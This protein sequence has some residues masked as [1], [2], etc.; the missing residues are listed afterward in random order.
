MH[1]A[2]LPELHWNVDLH[3]PPRPGQHTAVEPLARALNNQFAL[4]SAAAKARV[5]SGAPEAKVK[6]SQLQRAP[7]GVPLPKTSGSQP[8]VR[9]ALRGPPAAA[10]AAAEQ[11]ARPATAAVAQHKASSLQEALGLQRSASCDLAWR[12]PKALQLTKASLGV[13]SDG[14]KLANQSSSMPP[15]KRSSLGPG[16]A[17]AKVSV[18]AKTD[19]RKQPAE[20]GP[21][22]PGPDVGALRR[23]VCGR[24]SCLT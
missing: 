4:P 17:T 14:S 7:S 18:L 6:S 21:A 12:L 15:A 5:P 1:E 2:P 16:S 10:P 19:S 24:Q 20:P 22:A 11:E 8:S 13:P 23:C 3:Q 9:A